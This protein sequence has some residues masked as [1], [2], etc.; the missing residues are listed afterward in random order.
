MQ[1]WQQAMIA[2]IAVPAIGLMSL[3]IVRLS[4][5]PASNKATILPRCPP[6]RLHPSEPRHPVEAAVEG[7]DLL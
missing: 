7:D 5:R 6:S 3:A 2:I 4:S 1:M